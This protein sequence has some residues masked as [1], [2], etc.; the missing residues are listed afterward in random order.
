MGGNDV[1]SRSSHRLTARPSPE[2]SDLDDFSPESYGGL[3]GDEAQR[4]PA[5]ASR[6]SWLK[7]TRPIDTTL[8]LKRKEEDEGEG[9]EQ[10]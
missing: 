5:S 8:E 2:P 6:S 10:S 9:G 4:E 3:D 1:G 7:R